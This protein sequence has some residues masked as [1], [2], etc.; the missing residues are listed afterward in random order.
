[1][2]GMRR[3]VPL[4]TAAAVITIL[5]GTMYGMVQQTIRLS[6]YDAPHQAIDAYVANRDASESNFTRINL[7]AD[8]NV[9]VIAY[10]SDGRPIGGDGYLNGKLGVVPIGVLQHAHAG[11][12]NTVTWQPQPGVRLAVVVAK[13]GNSYILAGQSLKSYEDRIGQIGQVAFFGWLLALL[14]LG[15]G[16]A[17]T[18]K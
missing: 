8:S 6:A 17:L 14:V 1:M 9:F 7:A 3:Y 2:S 12:E 18:K 5:F 13:D 4:I 16:F 10:G 15:T 11:H